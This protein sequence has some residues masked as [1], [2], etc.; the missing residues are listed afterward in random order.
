MGHL[1]QGKKQVKFLLVAIVY[2]MKCV[3]AKALATITEAKIQN[4]MWKN[5]VCRFEM[6]RM[7]ISDNGRQFDNQGFCL[8]LGIKNKSPP[9]VSSG[10]WVNGSDE[11]EIVEDHQSLIRGGKRRIAR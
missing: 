11:L 10:Q 6:P 4:F 1:P 7:I 8:N 9:R 2:F 5:I 3:K